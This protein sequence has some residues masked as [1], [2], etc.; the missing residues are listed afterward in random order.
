MLARERRLRLPRVSRLSNALLAALALHGLLFLARAR[1]GAAPPAPLSSVASEQLVELEEPSPE[2]APRDMAMNAGEAQ[3]EAHSSA[4]DTT[5]RRMA[6]RATKVRAQSADTVPNPDGLADTGEGANAV[7]ANS[8]Q[9][10]P[11][12]PA[13]KID[14]GLDGHFFLGPASDVLPRVHKSA[15]QRQLEAS[16]AADDVKHGFARGNALV[17]SL[18]AATRDKGPVRGE[19][20]LSVTVGPDG[21]LT[22]LELLRG[23]ASDWASAMASFRELATRQRVRVPAGARGLR[24]TFSVK[25]K[26]QLPSGEEVRASVD[27]PSLAPNGL[28]LHGTFDVADVGSGPQRMVYAHIVSEEVL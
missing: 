3:S 27:G 7:A 8:A 26:V 1:H 12:A 28:T 4:S 5:A 14:L 18:N 23:S 22:D 19:A 24:V 11:D 10:Q 6:S 13:R 9:A 16:I 21:R 15:I 25:S 2:E 20:L 17:G